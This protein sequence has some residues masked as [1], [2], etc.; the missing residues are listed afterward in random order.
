MRCHLTP[1][2]VRSPHALTLRA[3]APGATGDRRVQSPTTVCFNTRLNLTTG[4][5][6][7]QKAST[8]GPGTSPSGITFFSQLVF[9][10]ISTVYPRITRLPHTQRSRQPYFGRP[11]I[12]FT[13]RTVSSSP[14]FCTQRDQ[15]PLR[16][17]ESEYRKSEPEEGKRTFMRSSLIFTHGLPSMEASLMTI[18]RAF[19]F[20]FPP[21]EAF[22][23]SFV[24]NV[25][26]P[27]EA[28][29]QH[30]K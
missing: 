24:R 20:S 4:G 2:S 29:S 15:R 26:I 23:K 22:A 14:V 27:N 1:P 6:L 21:V 30:K 16:S 19:D 9:M 8:S 13:M 3:N 18:F 12:S 5:F 11:K 10:S 25:P 7:R 28:N 17:V